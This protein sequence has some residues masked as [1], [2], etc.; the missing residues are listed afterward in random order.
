MQFA[1][2]FGL[3]NFRRI[4]K[5]RSNKAFPAGLAAGI[6]IAD[7]YMGMNTSFR[8]STRGFTLIELMI[9]V[10]IIGILAAMAITRFAE[11]AKKAKVSEVKPILKELWVC[12]EIYYSEFGVW[13]TQSTPGY[14]TW[15]NDGWS[16]IG[17]DPPSGEM[18]FCYH[19][20]NNVPVGNPDDII[21]A[22][23]G[24]DHSSEVPTQRAEASL[25]AV[26]VYLQRDGQILVSYDYGATFQ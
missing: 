7:L 16:E 1:M 15:I 4:F 14:H 5:K 9:V 11:A 19:Y 18:R 12:A 24:G 22:A 25:E 13:P 3:A 6:F 17:F 2:V 21:A 8:N 20:S 23:T 10:V 26:R